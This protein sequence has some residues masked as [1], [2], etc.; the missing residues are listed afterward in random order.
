MCCC[1]YPSL[2]RDCWL[3]RSRLGTEKHASQS[4]L[5]LRAGGFTVLFSTTILKL[6]KSA[7]PGTVAL[8]MARAAPS[9]Y[10][11]SAARPLPKPYSLVGVLTCVLVQ[12][13]ARSQ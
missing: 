7:A 8:L 1:C 2:G 10:V 13:Q 11:R 4:V 3:S 9:Q 6:L 12:E 5:V